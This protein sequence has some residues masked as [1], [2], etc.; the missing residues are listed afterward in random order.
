MAAFSISGLASGI[1]TASLISQLMVV[2]AAPQTQLKT[3]L[4]TENS[5]I[6]A[7]Q[8]IN[9][10]IAAV[11]TAA[12][13]LKSASTWSAATVASSNTSVVATASATAA[14]G[15]SAT[16]DVTQVA[17]AQTSTFAT[18]G[19]VVI[20]GTPPNFTITT[21]GNTTSITAASG[22]PAAVAAAINSAGVGV[23]ASV[24]NTDAGPILQLTST[25]TG[26]ANS[27][28]T[29]GLDSPQQDVVTAQNAQIT[30]GD[31]NNGGYTVSSSTNTFTDVIPGVT[32]TVSSLATGVNLS[33]SSDS[34]GMSSKVQ[35]LVDSVNAA[36]T[37]IGQATAQG[38]ILPSDS[39]STKLQQSLLSTV[40]QGFSG[41]SFNQYGVTLTS[42]GQV[43][44]DSA[45]FANAYSADPAGTQAALGT[46]LGGA[47][48]TL[49]IAAT[50]S[51]KGSL[52]LAVKNDQ[53]TAADYTKQISKWDSK[54]ADMQTALTAK[55]S[56]MES[57]LSKLQ[58]ESTWLTS[59]LASIDG[60]KSSSSS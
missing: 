47:Y 13:A 23:R 2:A 22:T 36:F 27:F 5:V 20:S 59:T 60:S 41:G 32:F 19:G 50:D 17:R 28:T 48:D 16:F 54:L 6:A 40:A 26:T 8:A 33:L 29:S 21:G 57:A 58:S 43:T 37:I 52:T 53:A 31:P 3:Q 7:Y 4:N 1:D 39:L 30:V 10:K 14:A 35:A 46:A 34:A 56:A 45:A 44:F 15:S 42:T 9:T 38:G 24:V 25:G 51:V 49:G 11:Q 12:E 55:Y 18:A